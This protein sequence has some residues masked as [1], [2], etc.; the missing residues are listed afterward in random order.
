MQTY[1]ITVGDISSVAL[2]GKMVQKTLELVWDNSSQKQEAKKQ[3]RSNSRINL[4]SLTSIIEKVEVLRGQTII[5]KL[6][7]RL[8]A[9]QKKLSSFCNEIKL[10]Q[11]AGMHIIIIHDFMVEEELTNHLGLNINTIEGMKMIA[12]GNILLHEMLMSLVA[13]KISSS[14]STE[15]V[16]AVCIS[17]KDCNL[18]TATKSSPSK[19]SQYQDSKIID[20]NMVGQ[21]ALVNPEVLL[22]LENSNI[23]TIISPIASSKTSNSYL[24]DADITAVL[25]AS[26]MGAE[27]IAFYTHLPEEVERKQ[28]S[29]LEARKMKFKDKEVRYYFN[30]ILEATAGAIGQG[31]EEVFLFNEMSITALTT[32]LFTEDNTG[33]KITE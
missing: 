20:I 23:V 16:S 28:M 8:V 24:L 11:K 26:S 6:S 2:G 5:I 30:N 1:I 9:D 29:L 4:K 12:G 15:G 14:L 21:P 31:V 25:I 19:K 32:S 17:G 3:A 10:L 18:I 33:I 27:K 7:S 22:N 13:K